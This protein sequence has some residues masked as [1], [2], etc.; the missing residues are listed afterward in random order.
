MRYALIDGAKKKRVHKVRDDDASM[1]VC[2][3]WASKF[4]RYS[5]RDVAALKGKPDCGNCRRVK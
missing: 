3:Q 1:T 5:R 4:D 2:G